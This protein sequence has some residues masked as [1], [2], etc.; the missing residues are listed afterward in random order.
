VQD[1]G[2]FETE[3]KSVLE[4]AQTIAVIISLAE[5]G[6][7]PGRRHAVDAARG[8]GPGV[9]ARRAGRRQRG[10]AA[11]PQRATEAMTGAAQRWRR[12]GG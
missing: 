4:V 9:A 2:T 10:P 12:S 3:R 7:E 8:Q 5:R 11:V 1:A 6:D